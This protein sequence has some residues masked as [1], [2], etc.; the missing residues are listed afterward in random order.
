MHKNALV[1]AAGRCVAAK[2]AGRIDFLAE[3]DPGEQVLIRKSLQVG[4]KLRRAAESAVPEPHAFSR[5]AG[6]REPDQTQ[7]HSR[8]RLGLM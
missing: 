3:V 2:V 5:T 1:I 4:R 7:L 6:K 8:R